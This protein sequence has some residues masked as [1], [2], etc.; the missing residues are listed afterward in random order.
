MSNVSS[1]LCFRLYVIERTSFLHEIE[2]KPYVRFDAPKME[3]RLVSGEK[4]NVAVS[5]VMSSGGKVNAP[6][7]TRTRSKSAPSTLADRVKSRVRIVSTGKTSGP[8]KRI[9]L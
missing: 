3:K 4:A 6:E 8:G 5:K 1:L 9:L 7:P 2:G